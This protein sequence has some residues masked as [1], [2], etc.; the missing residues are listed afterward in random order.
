[1]K[2]SST[3]RCPVEVVFGIKT[4][5]HILPGWQPG[6]YSEA[7]MPKELVPAHFAENGWADAD[8]EALEG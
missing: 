4:S 3:G 6:M 8:L 7:D 1:M 2:R 5:S